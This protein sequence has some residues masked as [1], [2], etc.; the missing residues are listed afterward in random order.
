MR[1]LL[2]ILLIGL[3]VSCGS[4]PQ[5]AQHPEV[6]DTNSADG[7]VE[8]LLRLARTSARPE[9]DSYLISALELLLDQE[10][11]ERVQV[12]LPGITSPENLSSNLQLRF[13]LVN[14]R[15]S[16][17]V[18]DAPA[19]LR[20][21]SGNL[22]AGAESE[23]LDLQQQFWFLRADAYVANGRAAE[24]ISDL[25]LQ[26]STNNTQSNQELRDHIWR[27]FDAL[28]DDE[29]NAM[30]S[31]V[32]SYEY[33]G[34]LEL[35]K[36]IRTEQDSIESQ[37][38][39]IRQWQSVW[40]QHSA[41]KGLPDG[42]ATLNR[43]WEQRPRRIALLL[44]LQDQ[45]GR[46]VQEGF[47]SAYYQALS[48]GDEV[49]SVHI[50]DTSPLLVSGSQINILGLYDTAVAAGANLIIGPLD[51]DLVRQLHALD[52]LTVPTLALNYSDLDYRNSSNFYQFGLAPQD[53]I[54]MAADLA[55]QAGH[56][57]AAVLAPLGPDYQRL[58][59]SFATYWQ[60]LGGELVSRSTYSG[61]ADYSAVIKHLLAIDASETRAATILRIL[62]RSEMEF[63]PRRRQDIDFI[64][65]MANPRQGRQI[66]P[67]L[68][69]YFADDIPVYSLSA[70]YDGLENQL[71]NRDLNG[72]IFT[73]APWV[74]RS[75]DLLKQEVNTYFRMA[76]GPLQRLRALGIDSFRLYARLQQLSN[77][78]ITSLDGS[79]GIL[80]MTETGSIQRKP[81]SAAFIDGLVRIIEPVELAA[82]SN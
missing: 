5:P 35:A 67:T 61:D 9:S 57:N 82:R 74:L 27:L 80:S 78:L 58:Q 49:P 14:A 42:L 11:L 25:I 19:T 72:I 23:V 32:D 12:F 71:A 4:S 81:E 65:L 7:S 1:T 48:Q 20:W 28:G 41:L 59:D 70:I 29:L 3:L 52:S 43:V 46:A 63:T 17:A 26:G 34:W 16:L 44:P 66:K 60:S 31:R 77:G 13:A 24:A 62:P 10:E 53:E 38:D 45:V 68:S 69:F 2:F 21:L 6:A 56:R 30:T 40:T 36:S 73:D 22:V 54:R 64:Y 8:S 15:Y 79:T 39:V 47:L 33:R 76:Q 37:L 18:D 51:K 55:W 75:D 50:Y